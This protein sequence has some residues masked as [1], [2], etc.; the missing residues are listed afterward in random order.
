SA[1]GRFVVSTRYDD[2]SVYRDTNGYADV[3]LSDVLNGTSVAV[4]II[5][6][7]YVT[8]FDGGAGPTV[9]FI[10]NTNA[11]ESPIISADGST[12]YAVRRSPG[13][14]TRIYGALTTNAASGA[15]M[16]LASRGINVS[17]NG[18]SS[19]PSTSSNGLLLAFTST[20]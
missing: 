12:I 17:E 19:S 13:G 7:A 5:S 3:F 8:N 14:R 10:E 6:N 16:S 4:S 18:N 11:F 9:T 2:P 15:G 20:S 1:D